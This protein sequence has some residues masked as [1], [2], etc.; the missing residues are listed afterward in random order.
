MDV[1]VCLFVCMCALMGGWWTVKERGYGGP[2]LYHFEFGRFDFLYS[3]AFWGWP[4]PKKSS[5]PMY[6][7]LI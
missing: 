6:G 3:G 4:L 1:I 2:P 7:M 5:V